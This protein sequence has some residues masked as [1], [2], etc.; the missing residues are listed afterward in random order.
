MRRFR[1]TGGS[2]CKVMITAPGPAAVI[3]LCLS[4]LPWVCILQPHFPSPISNALARPRH[5]AILAL[6]LA[7]SSSSSAAGC[8][9]PSAV[10]LP[11]VA[12]PPPAWRRPLP[13]AQCPVPAASSP[14]PEPSTTHLQRPRALQSDVSSFTLAARVA[15]AA[16]RLHPPAS[17][18]ACPS[19]SH[20]AL[21]LASGQPQ[22]DTDWTPA[23]LRK[24][25][26]LISTPRLHSSHSPAA[27]APTPRRSISPH[28]YLL[29]S[30]DHLDRP[31][32]SV[33]VSAPPPN[34]TLPSPPPSVRFSHAHL[35]ASCAPSSPW[36]LRQSS[37]QKP[38]TSALRMLPPEC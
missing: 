37:T 31:H 32:R 23:L 14:A 27:L 8:P 22:T 6:A 5:P 17:R 1:A 20:C 25:S 16:A 33:P 10:C 30:P 29:L 13:R 36:W 28:Y 4:P 24:P 3:G 35:A 19:R 12:C 18:Y 26:P 15:R 9:R 38:S 11:P 21:A 2:R 7:L 34:K